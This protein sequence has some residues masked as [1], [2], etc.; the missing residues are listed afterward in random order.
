MAPSPSPRTALPLLRRRVTAPVC[1][2]HTAV[3]SPLWG[4]SHPTPFS[5]RISPLT[6]LPAPSTGMLGSP[7][8]FIACIG[9][10]LPAPHTAPSVLSPP[11]PPPR[12]FQC[13]CG[14]HR[15]NGAPVPP[16]GGIAVP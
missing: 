15:L 11:F 8:D 3:P 14:R 9:P 5:F 10:L 7:C 6:T 2:F 1:R 12:V 4:P 16:G 13:A